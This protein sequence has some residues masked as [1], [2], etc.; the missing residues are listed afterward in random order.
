MTKSNL[1]LFLIISL[2]FMVACSD[3][4]GINKQDLTFI[5]S[6]K[7]FL[8]D[9][10]VLPLLESIGSDYEYLQAPSCVYEGNDKSFLYDDFEIYTY[11]LN[12]KDLIDEIIVLT[13]HYETNRG[14]KVGSSIDDVKKA[15]G[16]DY[17][18]QGGLIT[19]S[20]NPKDPTSPVIYFYFENDMVASIHYYS[21]SNISE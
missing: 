3:N 6:G 18:D 11:P 10:D 13:P 7:S 1:I 2:L 5:H 17:I 4:D 12:G 8:L 16:N 15:Y 19:F 9:S 14:I 21:A 20:Q